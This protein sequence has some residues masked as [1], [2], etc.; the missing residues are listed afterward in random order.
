[1]FNS[2]LR[3]ISNYL[4]RVCV[5]QIGEIKRGY[6]TKYLIHLL[7]KHFDLSDRKIPLNTEVQENYI[8]MLEKIGG[9]RMNK[10]SL[11]GLAQ[12]DYM[13][14]TVASVH[15]KIEQMGGKWDEIIV[16]TTKTVSVYKVANA[17]SKPVYYLKAIYSETETPQ[18]NKFFSLLSNFGW[19]K[20]TVE[21]PDHKKEVLIT[22]FS[23]EKE[24]IWSKACFLRCHSPGRSY[25]MD[26]KYI[27][28]HLNIGKDLCLFNYRGTHLSTGHPSEGGYYLDAESVF[29]E[30]INTWSYRP[31]QIWATGFCL[32]GAV[33]A[34][35]K[36]KYHPL[37][38]NYVGENTFTSLESVIAH[39]RWPANIMGKMA[40]EAIKSSDSEIISKV[41]QDAFNTIEKFHR[42]GSS[43]NHAISIIINTDADLILPKDSGLRLFLAARK[44]GPAY[45]ITHISLKKGNPHSDNVFD[46]EKTWKGYVKI[47]S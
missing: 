43:T 36:F 42:L 27:G 5:F 3:K 22:Y 28:K 18:W 31:N 37:G 20:A 39:Q 8:K 35:L 9:I 2:I 4:L 34:Y 40:I 25:G 21:Y 11:D 23:S 12:I 10:S 13:I 15:K 1:M 33:A 14:L 24:P 46:D 30:L 32:G 45:Q 41:Q 38:V 29:Q 47:V 26:Q 19:E 7:K 16:E 6:F 44:F 17:Q